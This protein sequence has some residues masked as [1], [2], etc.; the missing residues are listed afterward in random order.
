MTLPP[1]VTTRLVT[2]S[3]LAA[4]AVGLDVGPVAKAGGLGGGQGIG[5]GGSAG[6]AVIEAAIGVV[7]GSMRRRRGFDRVGLGGHGAFERGPRGTPGKPDSPGRDPVPAGDAG[8]PQIRFVEAAE[9]NAI[10]DAGLL[11]DAR[12]MGPGSARAPLHHAMGLGPPPVRSD[13]SFL[14]PGG[15]EIEEAAGAL[16]DL[17]EGRVLLA[18]GAAARDDD[19]AAWRVP[20]AGNDLAPFVVCHALALQ[21][22]DRHFHLGAFLRDGQLPAPPPGPVRARSGSGLVDAYD[23]DAAVARQALVEGDALLQA[24]EQILPDGMPSARGLGAAAD[25]ARATL[26]SERDHDLSRGEP[27]PDGGIALARRLFP[28][29]A[30]VAFVAALRARWSWAEIDRVLWAR[31]PAS[32]EEVLHPDAYLRGEVPDPVAARLPLAAL[33]GWRVAAEDT[34]GELGVSA[35]LGASVGD[36]RAARA[37]AGWAGDRAVWLSSS[38]GGD[39]SFAVWITTWD[40]ETDARDFEEQATVALATLTEI[41]PPAAPTALFVNP[42]GRRFAIETAPRTVGL[43][44][45]AP[46]VGQ[47]IL[48][49]LIAAAAPVPTASAAVRAP[50]PPRGIRPGFRRD[51]GAR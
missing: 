50:V 34:L 20:D 43:L 18:A 7:A 6:G 36:Y 22:L 28:Q 27:H 35:F 51:P 21:I 49:R 33:G 38:S 3:L 48:H 5:P 24:L 25:R 41:S 16:Y 29:T 30:G 2:L 10:V 19:A 31:P 45:S 9:L 32:T 40:D 44:F 17:A 26:L 23:G 13:A 47:T 46:E 15:R 42:A 4:A 11:A 12:Q 1:L 14:G 8:P 37:A 39:E